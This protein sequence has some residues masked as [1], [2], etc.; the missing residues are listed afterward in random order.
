MV[1][2]LFGFKHFRVAEKKSK[3]NTWSRFYIQHYATSPQKT[4]RRVDFNKKGLHSTV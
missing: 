2:Q 3:E 4:E 1:F